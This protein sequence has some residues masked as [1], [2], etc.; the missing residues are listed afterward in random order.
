MSPEEVAALL[1]YIAALDNREVTREMVVAWSPLLE[2]ADGETA[3]EA[4]RNH[5][6]TSTDYLM[7]AHVVTYI[8][9][10]RKR[11]AEGAPTPPRELPSRFEPDPERM[12]RMLTGGALA[13]Q[14][15]DDVF[16]RR[17]AEPIEITENMSRSDQ[18]RARALERARRERREARQTER[19][20]R[21]SEPVIPKPFEPVRADPNRPGAHCGRTGCLCTHTEGCDGGWIEVP[22][23]QVGYEAPVT[24]CATC[25]PHA[26]AIFATTVTRAEK[27]RQLRQTGRDIAEAEKRQGGTSQPQQW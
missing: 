2:M 20:A 14:T 21:L 16:E 6:A 24:A 26:A 12:Q 10:K 9:E 5:F 7:P 15:I 17:K 25:K 8:R 22:P 1:A 18:I 13:Q 23:S 27:Q 3:I 19:Q 4:V 11:D